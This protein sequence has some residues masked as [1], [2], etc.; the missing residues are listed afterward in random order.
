MTLFANERLVQTLA[1]QE[2]YDSAIGE[3][4]SLSERLAGTPKGV[5]LLIDAAKLAY[6]SL[7][8]TTRAADILD[9]AGVLY[10]HL[11]VGKW[12]SNEA[13]RLRRTMSP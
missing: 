12:A 2:E 5:A 10:G 11:D 9:K 7:A 1:L 13:T 8:E 6:E 3:M 4:L